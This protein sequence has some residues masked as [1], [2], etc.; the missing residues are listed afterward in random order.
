M[1]LDTTTGFTLSATPG[2][3]GSVSVVPDTY[4]TRAFATYTFGFIV[5]NALAAGGQITI[6]IPTEVTVISTSLTFSALSNTLSTATLAYDTTTRIIKLTNVFSGAVA[7]QTVVKF[8][9]GG[10]L[11]NPQTTKPSSVFI[12]TTLDSSSNAIDQN[13]LVT[14]TA[15]ANELTNVG[16]TACSN[17]LSSSMTYQNCTYQLRI[18]TGALYPIQANSYLEI[19]LPSELGINFA[20][21][22]LTY[23]YTEGVEDAKKVVT[24]PSTRTFRFT[25]LFT[26]T[27]TSKTQYTMDLFSVYL[28][29]LTTPRSTASTSSFAVRIYDSLGYLQYEKK[30]QIYSSVA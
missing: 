13:S 15:T 26:P 22:T 4:R 3:L 9:I 27:D 21:D 12:I 28:S 8:A 18:Y 5:G 14:V 17:V 16:V 30:S 24:Q 11:Y 29:N 10:G 25:K 2:M 7:A 23:S 19:D 1:T 6:Q 20:T